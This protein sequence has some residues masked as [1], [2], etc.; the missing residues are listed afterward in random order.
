[1]IRAPPWSTTVASLS[2][3]PPANEST[4]D[5]PECLDNRW[6]NASRNSRIL[7]SEEAWAGMIDVTPVS[8][9]EIL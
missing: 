8:F 9:I 4:D 5:Q 1:M 3:L 7:R 6:P 2:A